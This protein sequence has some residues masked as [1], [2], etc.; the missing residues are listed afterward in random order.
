MN[1]G[2]FLLN[3]YMIGYYKRVVYVDTFLY[4]VLGE[5][6]YLIQAWL[7]KSWIMY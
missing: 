3:C 5:I 4:A 6:T 7:M 2:Q 1:K